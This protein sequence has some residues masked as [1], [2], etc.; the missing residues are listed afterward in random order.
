M[1]SSPTTPPGD[2]ARKDLQDAMERER[3]AGERVRRR[4]SQVKR[5]MARHKSGKAPIVPLRNA[6]RDEQ[7][8]K[9]VV[10]A[11]REKRPVSI[12]ARGGPGVTDYRLRKRRIK[13]PAG[14]MAE[15]KFWTPPWDHAGDSLKA[16]AWSQVMAERDGEAF[17]LKL[18]PEVIEAGRNSVNGFVPYMLG[19]IRKRLA[20]ASDGPSDQAE[21]FL[22]IEAGYDIPAHVHGAIILPETVEARERWKGAL[23]DAGGGYP[24]GSNQLDIR[25]LRG[26]A[27][28]A[29]YS[30]KWRLGTAIHIGSKQVCAC[31]N[32]IRSAARRWYEAARQD[33]RVL[34]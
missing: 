25:E 12:V 7:I 4:A 17:T 5:A 2:A 31:T 21:L 23:R 3:A 9:G 32:G 29:R 14:T 20:Q 11:L 15:A 34:K 19:R 22:F 33:G 27:G 30:S 1:A 28:W 16:L 24:H 6:S 26:P 13:V 8:A 18:G 10:A